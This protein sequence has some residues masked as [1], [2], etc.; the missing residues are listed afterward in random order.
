VL[1]K[2]WQRCW[3][4]LWVID[5]DIKGFFDSID[6]TLLM[7]AVDKH[8]PSG[9]VGFYVKRWLETDVQFNDGT[10]TKRSAGTSQVGVISPLLANLFLHYAFDKWMRKNNP[11]IS[12]IRSADDILVH[13]QSQKEAET[14]LGVV[15]HMAKRRQGDNRNK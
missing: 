8:L 14:L 6:H 1:L 12:F 13:C 10:R 5:L 7:K 2:R 15:M 11:S 3:Q 4:S 9:W